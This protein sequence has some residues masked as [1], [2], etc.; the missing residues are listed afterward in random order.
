MAFAL[1]QSARVQ[2]VTIPPRT[3]LAAKQETARQLGTEIESLDPAHTETLNATFVGLDL[4]EGLTRIDAAGNVVPRAATAWKNSA[5]DTCVF[6]PRHDAKWSNGRPV[7]AADF[8]YAWQR[9]VDPKTTSLYT[10][11]V[12]FTQ[13]IKT[14][15]PG[16]SSW[17]SLQPAQWRLSIA[18]RSRSSAATGR[19]SAT[20]SV[21]GRICS[22]TGS[23]TTASLVAHKKGPYLHKK[24][25]TYTRKHVPV[26]KM[27]TLRGK[28]AALGFV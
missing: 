20:S 7:T 1:A 2:A 19:V 16:R 6:N 12:E 25:F 17:S 8:L 11:A 5:P 4:Y 9:L 14:E 18:R 27:C 22:R 15:T 23:R 13:E 3:A 21:M 24:V 28:F 10:T 26:K